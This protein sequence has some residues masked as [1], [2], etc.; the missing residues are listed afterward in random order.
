MSRLDKGIIAYG[1]EDD[2]H[3]LAILAGLQN[4]SVSE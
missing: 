2:R 4:Q 3:R 1:T